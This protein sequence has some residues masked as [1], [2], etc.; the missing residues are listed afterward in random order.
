MNAFT[1]KEYT[2]FHVRAL[3]ES[4][5]LALD[6]LADILCDPAFRPEEVEAERQVILEE[7]LMRED[8]PGDLVHEVLADALFPGHPLG[9]DVLGDE[10]RVKAMSGA[11]IRAFWAEHYRPGNMVFAAA[12]RL[13]HDALVAGIERRFRGAAGGSTP[14]RTPPSVDVEPFAVDERPTEQ[15][16]VAIGVRS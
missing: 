15:A 2:A 11:D 3:D 12:G 16:H 1:T 9:L 7:I 10:E 14:K 6:I 13:E 5:E 8:E 4:I